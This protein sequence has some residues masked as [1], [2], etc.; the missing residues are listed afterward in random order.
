MNIM[1]SISLT[2]DD[3]WVDTI[4]DV[5]HKI[6]LACGGDPDKDTCTLSVQPPTGLA[7]YFEPPPTPVT[8]P[9]RGV[10]MGAPDGDS[11]DT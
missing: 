2:K 9:V 11:T 3:K 8:P 1:C 6:L 10:E 4:D 7:G 5:A